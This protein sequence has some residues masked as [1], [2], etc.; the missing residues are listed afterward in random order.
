MHEI[1]HILTLDHATNRESVMYP[2]TQP[3][4]RSLSSD[5]IEGIQTLYGGREVAVPGW[6]GSTTAAADVAVADL[7]GTGALDLLVGHIDDPSGPNQAYYRVGWQ[8]DGGG[9]PVLGWSPP[10]SM[11]GPL[12]H[13][14]QGMGLAV[15]DV[16]GSGRPDLVAV[17]IDDP[18]GD[19]NAF[20][21]I[22]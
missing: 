1:G 3:G 14:N 15:G 21:R 6:F 13:A 2:V 11:G 7:S 19:N 12:G 18:G 5:D 22:G 17:F 10:L 4:L 20:Y 9:V 8:L 16:N